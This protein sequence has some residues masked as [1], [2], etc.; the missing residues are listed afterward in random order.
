MPALL[1]NF[2]VGFLLLMA[3][4]SDHS[5]Y[6]VAFTSADKAQSSSDVG[7]ISLAGD[8]YYD[9]NSSGEDDTGSSIV[10]LDEAYEQPQ[11]MYDDGGSYG[12]HDGSF[13][14]FSDNNEGIASSNSSEQITVEIKCL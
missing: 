10:L 13:D 8:L 9:F 6:V 1:A 5:L 12:G 14:Y 2:I 7:N 3:S 4:I 11:F